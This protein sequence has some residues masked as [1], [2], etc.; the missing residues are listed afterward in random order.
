MIKFQPKND[1]ILVRRAASISRTKGGLLLPDVAQD[2]AL[3]GEVLAVADRV[4][5]FAVGD[6]VTFGRYAG[7]DMTKQGPEFADCLLFTEKDIYGVLGQGVELE[8]PT[9]PADEDE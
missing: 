4:T 3:R 6:V 8:I 2:Q 7:T 1:K 9:P 5:T